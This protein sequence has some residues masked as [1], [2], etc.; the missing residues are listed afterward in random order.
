ML[1]LATSESL[2]HSRELF[3]IKVVPI[4]VLQQHTVTEEARTLTLV[5]APPCLPVQATNRRLE[6]V[7]H[8]D[9]HHSL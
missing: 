1:K 6:S 8:L 5:A 7:Y 4:A 9:R 2:E 3:A